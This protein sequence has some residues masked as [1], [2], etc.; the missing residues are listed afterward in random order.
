MTFANFWL[1]FATKFLKSQ[2]MTFGKM[3]AFRNQKFPKSRKSHFLTLKY[4][5]FGLKYFTSRTTP[6]P[7]GGVWDKACR[8]PKDL[9]STFLKYLSPMVHVVIPDN[10]RGG[11][12]PPSWERRHGGVSVDSP[13]SKSDPSK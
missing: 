13:L 2:K 8:G 12:T 1:R 11:G 10:R 6:P 4:F 9:Y 5:G 7:P 3:I